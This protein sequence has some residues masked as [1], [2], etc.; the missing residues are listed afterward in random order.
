[1]GACN[2]GGTVIDWVMK[3]DGVSFRH[4]IGGKM[5]SS[6]TFFPISGNRFDTS[7]ALPD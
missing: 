7:E 4:C 6:T 2:V 5:F 3:T 1:L